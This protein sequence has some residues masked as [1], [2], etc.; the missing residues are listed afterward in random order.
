MKE[1]KLTLPLYVMLP[2]KTMKD[3]RH[4]LNMNVH[5]GT[6]YIVRNQAKGIYHKI[7]KN[8]LG[9]NSIRFN[10]KIQ[11]EY[12]YFHGSKRKVDT[13]NPCSIIDKYTCDALVEL[14]VFEDDN[15]SI[16]KR[17]VFEWGGVD[18]DNPR[19]ELTIKEFKDEK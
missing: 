19:C 11:L 2:R 9:D 18:K 12:I 6:C 16:L 1:L 8:I 13:N 15:S 3:K 17:T 5:N 4:T 14:G 10:G 7:V